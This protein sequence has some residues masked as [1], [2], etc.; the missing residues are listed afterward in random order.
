MVRALFPLCLLADKA[1]TY[2]LS[3]PFFQFHKAVERGWKPRI[4][5]PRLDGNKKMGVFGSRSPLRPNF[6]GQSVVN[7]KNV[8]QAQGI[9]HISGLDLLDQT[10]VIDIKPYIPYTDSLPHASEGYSPKP[11]HKVQVIFTPESRQTCATD[12]AQYGRN[13]QQLIEQILQ[14]DPRPAYHNDDRSYGMRLW[15]LNIRFTYVN[16]TITVNHIQQSKTWAIKTKKD[17]D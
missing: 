8:D 2:H 16:N 13:L 12:Q 5:P 9:I 15:D 14:Q 1:N 3:H 7:I 11:V 4:R 17:T 10:P 6:L